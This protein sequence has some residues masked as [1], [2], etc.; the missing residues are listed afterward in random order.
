MKLFLAVTEIWSRRSLYQR[1]FSYEQN[2]T[3]SQLKMDGVL[4]TVLFL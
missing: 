2:R 1:L 3:N 4:S